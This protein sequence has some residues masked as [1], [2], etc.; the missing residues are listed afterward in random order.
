M[1]SL[2]RGAAVCLLCV[3]L[4]SEGYARV[5]VRVAPGKSAAVLSAL[6]SSG[7]A[8]TLKTTLSPASGSGLQGL[9]MRPMLSV[10]PKGI[11][12]ISLDAVESAQSVEFDGAPPIIKVP[13]RVRELR[14]AG[15]LYVDIKDSTVLFQNEGNRR[16]QESVTAYLDYIAGFSRLHGGRV[17]RRLGDGLLIL[18]D[19]GARPAIEAAEAIQGRLGE[20]QNMLG[21]E[22]L[23]LH[24]AVSAGRVLIE[25]N[26]TDIEVYGQTVERTIELLDYSDGGSV[27]VEPVL[28]SQPRMHEFLEARSFIPGDV[29]LLKPGPD[30]GGGIALPGKQAALTTHSFEPRA[31]LFT[32]LRGWSKMY[33]KHGRRPA[34]AAAKAFQA[35][36]AAI[37]QLNGG[38]VVKTR[39]EGL[40]LSF[41]SAAEALMAAAEMQARVRELKAATPLGGE[42]AIRTGISYGKVVVERTLEGKDHFG[43]TV[44]AAARLLDLNGDGE[45]L[46]SRAALRDKRLRSLLSRSDFV[47][48]KVRLKG[49]RDE[50][51]VLRVRPASV[52]RGKPASMRKKLKLLSQAFFE[53][54]TRA[55]RKDAD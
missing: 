27:V 17:V 10:G 14:G 35:Y 1:V 28:F 41:P 2:L 53:A 16:S 22:P 13:D 24:A 46:V 25:E 8:P 55:R 30:A 12:D 19:G 38:E 40:M 4:P 51:M 50:V 26:G 11:G 37:A 33:D 20:W 15:M 29:P 42:M 45:V 36:A 21:G 47:V 23:E 48:E 49:F 7:A 54:V 5:R 31:T 6:A 18:F 32:D 39:G 3:C 34:F 9:A 43:N 52:Y 44:N